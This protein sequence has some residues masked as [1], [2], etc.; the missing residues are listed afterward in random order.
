VLNR[1]NFRSVDELKTKILNYIE[2][3]NKIAKPMKWKCEQK[4]T[5]SNHAMKSI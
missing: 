1:G 4:A 3:Y 2:F 5:V